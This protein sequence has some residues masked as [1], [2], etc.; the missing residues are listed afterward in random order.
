MRPSVVLI[1]AAL[2]Y[3]PSVAGAQTPAPAAPAASAAA[4]MQFEGITLG[5]PLASLTPQLGDPVQVAAAGASVIWRYLE[6]GGDYYLDVLVKNNNATSVTVVQRMNAAR[7]TDPR[8]ISFGMTSKQVRAAIGA[9]WRTNTNSD[10]GSVDLWYRAG[11]YAWIYEFYSDKLGFIQLVAAPSVQQSFAAGPSVTPNDGVGPAGA[12]RIRP[13][14]SAFNSIWIDAYLAMNRCGNGGHWKE[15]SRELTAGDA[16]KDPL[17]YTVVHARCTD[18]GA[19]RAMY[20]D[21]RGA[22]A[23]SPSPA[24]SATPI[25]S[26]E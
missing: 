20:F 17:A 14:S 12:I 18:G 8:G 1:L 2:L 21:T 9:P 23:A 19:D 3:C 15:T 4:R 26:K 25:E 13:S 11:D 7:Y 22:G 5:A 24:P 10:D 16:T 6:G